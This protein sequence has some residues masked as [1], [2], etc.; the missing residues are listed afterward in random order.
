MYLDKIEKRALTMA[1]V[2][3][4]YERYIEGLI[5]GAAA[6]RD[7]FQALD[8]RKQL[9]VSLSALTLEAGSFFDRKCEDKED[10]ERA[11]AE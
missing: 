2:I 1:E 8:I 4:R 9:M 5:D 7:D 10:A 6:A 3:R 11:K